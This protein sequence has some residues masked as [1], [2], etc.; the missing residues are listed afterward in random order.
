MPRFFVSI[1]LF[2][3]VVCTIIGSIWLTFQFIRQLGFT[4]STCTVIDISVA[5]KSCCDSSEAWRPPSWHGYDESH[6][7]ESYQRHKRFER[8][9]RTYTPYKYRPST[10]NR[11]YACYRPF[12]IVQLSPLK[13][14]KAIV[15]MELHKDYTTYSS[16]EQAQV[17]GTR[18]VIF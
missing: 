15:T 9:P 5:M 18:H 2:F 6:K 8:I 12:L 11:C 16:T 7:H 13:D 14:S 17:S 3:G 10:P 1:L 4:N